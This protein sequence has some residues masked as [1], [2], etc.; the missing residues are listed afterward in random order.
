MRRAARR[1]WALLCLWLAGAAPALSGPRACVTDWQTVGEVCLVRDPSGPV[2]GHDVLGDVPEWH[3]LSLTSPDPL[4]P[5][6]RLRQP[7]HIFEDIAPRFADVTGD[8]FPEVIAVQADFERGARLAVFS[9]EGGTLRL[10]AAT[11]HIGQRHRWLA[12]VG[13]A[14]MDGDGAVE[15]A[16][17]DRPHLAKRL[18]V[19]RW[20][21]GGLSHV[22]DMDGLTNHRI[23]WNYIAGGWRACSGEMILASADW[24][25]IRAISL[26]GGRLEA[27]DLGPLGPEGLAPALR[28]PG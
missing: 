13:I 20:Q 21:E 27:A 11:P 15:L 6:V 22:A 19:W 8:G 28:C 17:I 2:Y 16:Y 4:R 5:P 10:L 24:T 14:D 7:G 26:R 1:A 25:H 12:V 23:G 3:F 9:A 18:R